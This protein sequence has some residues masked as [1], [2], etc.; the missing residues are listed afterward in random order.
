MTYKKIYHLQEVCQKLGISKSTY[1]RYE[2]SKI[3]P[4][5][6]KD[7]RG[8]RFFSEKDIEKYSIRLAKTENSM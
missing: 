3:L 2:K 1:L 6:K 4:K 7:G 5:A 8:W